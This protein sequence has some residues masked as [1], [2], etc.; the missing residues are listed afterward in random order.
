LKDFWT[1]RPAHYDAVALTH[2]GCDITYRDLSDRAD[3]WRGLFTALAQAA[4]PLVALEFETTPE[5]IAAY[6]GALRANF[7]LLIIEP[8]QFV[9]SSR[10]A[11]LYRPEILVT[12]KNGVLDAC[13]TGLTCIEPAPHPELRLLLSTSGSTGDPKLVRLS[14]GNIVSNAAAISTYLNLCPSDRAA[15]TLP[16]FYS[17]GLSVLNSYLGAGASLAIVKDSVA[18][19]SFWAEARE[20]GVTS[21]ALLPHQ[22]EVL[23][24]TGFDRIQ[25]PTLRYITQ[26][27]GRLDPALARQAFLAGREQG[28]DLVLMYGQTEAAPRMS[29][30]P[31]N[32]LPDAADTIGYA[33][34]GGRL[35]LVAED[36]AEISTPGRQGELVYEGPNVMMGYSVRR[37]DISRGPEVAELRTGDLAEF[38]TNGLVRITGRVKRF[39]KLYG[40]RLNLDQIEGLLAECGIVA[41]AIA[42]NDELVLLHSH[43]EQGPAA[44]KAIS[45]SYRL[46]TAHLHAAYLPEVPRLPSGKTD[47]RKLVRYA[48]EAVQGSEPR[49]NKELD[50]E[51]LFRQTIRMPQVRPTDSFASLGADSLSYLEMQLAL[52]EALGAAPEGWEHMTVVELVAAL[53]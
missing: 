19:P 27:G 11:E 35:R 20:A 42:L 28:W 43:P 22:I 30:V 44:C 21:L 6:L 2:G 12:R 32:L 15:T 10:L 47:Y 17:Y 51:E 49:K 7:P 48:A 36:G 1:F 16:L 31:P 34:P 38:T 8:G 3:A 5:A 18:E 26:A 39:I 9:R 50:I 25:L 37:E 23:S 29:Y 13:P 40:L 14:G 33:I 4:R 52:D 45:T 46:P 53:K 24:A 41:Q